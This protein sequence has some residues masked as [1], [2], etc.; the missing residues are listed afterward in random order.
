M[1]T[2]GAHC[3]TLTNE[4][5]QYSCRVVNVDDEDIMFTQFAA[6]REPAIAIILTL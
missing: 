4:N 6:L 1:K 2:V 5:H 3:V